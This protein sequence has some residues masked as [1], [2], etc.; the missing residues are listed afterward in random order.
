MLLSFSDKPSS[1]SDEAL[2]SFGQ[3][4]LSNVGRTGF[5]PAAL[6]LAPFEA[7]VVK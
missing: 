1:F 3:V 2:S 4:A 7:V 5:D 6:E